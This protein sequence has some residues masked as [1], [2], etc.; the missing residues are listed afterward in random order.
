M[1]T[2]QKPAHLQVLVPRCPKMSSRCPAGTLPGT[3]CKGSGTG[4]IAC[5]DGPLQ[6]S[7]DVFGH[8]QHD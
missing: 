3:S 7:R 2:A 6:E 4:G 8:L 5:N 1:P